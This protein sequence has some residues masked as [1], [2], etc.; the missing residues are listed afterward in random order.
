[1][2]ADFVRVTGFSSKYA[3][4]V[5]STAYLTAMEELNARYRTQGAYL[6]CRPY[7]FIGC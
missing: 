3:P 4:S 6:A 1:M 7:F 2:P 5:D